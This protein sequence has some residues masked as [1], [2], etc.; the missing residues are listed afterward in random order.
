MTQRLRP[1]GSQLW[2]SGIE[3]LSLTLG[4]LLSV[5]TRSVPCGF[6]TSRPWALTQTGQ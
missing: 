4:I 3:Q 1:A 6:W 2:Q 5:S